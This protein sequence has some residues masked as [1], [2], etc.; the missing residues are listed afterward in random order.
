MRKNEKLWTDVLE[1]SAELGN[2]PV[3]VL[4]DLNVCPPSSPT[5]RAAMATGRWMDAAVE[6]ASA[7]SGIVRPTCYANSGSP[8]SRVDAILLNNV[9][10]ALMTKFQTI[11]TS[12]LP[13]HLPI[14]VELDVQAY[15]QQ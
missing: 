6:Y 5:W 3:F 8:G 7:S 11:Y 2:V 12:G 1:A 14:A 13:T 4:G 10:F 15:G 9:A